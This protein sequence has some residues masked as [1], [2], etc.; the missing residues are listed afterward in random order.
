MT[1]GDGA[2][3]EW[4]AQTPFCLLYVVDFYRFRDDSGGDAFVE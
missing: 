2:R 1:A 4:H 3:I